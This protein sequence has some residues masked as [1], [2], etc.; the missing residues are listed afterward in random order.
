MFTAALTCHQ[1]M[2]GFLDFV[3]PFGEQEYA[4]DFHFSNFIAENQ[5]CNDVD[6]N[7]ARRIPELGRSGRMF[8]MCFNL[9]SVEKTTHSTPEWPW[10]IR[11]TAVYHSFDIET[12]RTV[13]IVVKGNLEIRKRVLDAT[14]RG[15]SSQ[16]EGIT[17]F[18]DLGSALGAS[19][20]VQLILCDWAKENW[21]W[22]INFLEERFR[23]VTEH[24]LYT[25][26]D[27]APMANTEPVRP[28]RSRTLPPE[29]LQR[30]WTFSSF[31]RATVNRV[32]TGT[33]SGIRQPYTATQSRAEPFNPTTAQR[34]ELLEDKQFSFNQ[35]Q[36]VQGLEEKSNETLLVLKM[37][38]NTLDA[39]QEHY[40]V[41]T[42]EDGWLDELTET[43][44][45]R[46]LRFR[47]TVVATIND[48]KMQQ[49]RLETLIRTLSD[50]KALVIPVLH[51]EVDTML[52]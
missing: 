42:Q 47:Q 23:N 27:R 3:F 26:V 24:S 11:Q 18:G 10:S 30:W 9:R 33:T 34:P 2:P 39:L 15:S 8:Q 32:L 25:A 40:R 48:L 7:V 16:R 44:H 52:T 37:N 41:V 6:L 1:V 14:T 51:L 29:P 12:G 17:N 35:L 20:N 19:L 36:D 13:W 21:R 45:N 22:Y 4:K 31:R 38:V 5:F 46:I 49:S 43:A 50:R 28:L